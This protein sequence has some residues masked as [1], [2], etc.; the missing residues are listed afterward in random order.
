MFK[1]PFKLPL[2]AYILA[3]PITCAL[4]AMVTM[5][6][7]V[8]AR[9]PEA[10]RDPAFYENEAHAAAVGSNYENGIKGLFDLRIRQRKFSVF[11][12]EVI[13]PK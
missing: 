8:P 10:T 1:L 7:R 2:D 4:G 9:D 3:V 12:N 5:T 13:I 6:A 11:N